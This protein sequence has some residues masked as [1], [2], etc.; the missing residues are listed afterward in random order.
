MP[1]KSPGQGPDLGGGG[2]F[3]P[4][5]GG[6]G[7]AARGRPAQRPGASD[8]GGVEGVA[9][10][11]WSWPWGGPSP[12]GRAPSFLP[13]GVCVCPG[14]LTLVPVQG[15]VPCRA[16]EFPGSETG[17]LQL[18]I[19]GA[20]GP[21]WRRNQRRE[22]VSNGT[23]VRPLTPTRRVRSPREGL[24]RWLVVPGA[25]GV[26]PRAGRAEPRSPPP[27]GSRLASRTP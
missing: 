16:G 25:R 8:R 1:R 5:L 12:R 21:A 22:K 15:R 10:V 3:V 18:G 20:P 6:G 14:P 11:G 9:H 13:R 2:C 4:L 26:G 27:D 19:P 23:D 17:S 24:A 7:L